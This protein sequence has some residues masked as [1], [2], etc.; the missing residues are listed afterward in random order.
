LSTAI[1]GQTIW[2]G[3]IFFDRT[4]AILAGGLMAIWPIQVAY[5]TI[6]ASELPFTFMV[7]LGFAAWFSSRPSKSAQAAVC[8]LAFGAASYVRPVALLLP[9]ILWL[10]I[11]PS[12]KKLGERLPMVVI[13]T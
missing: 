1:V 4:I 6:L 12:W 3:R 9:I 13:V 2:L 11:V 5:V 8:G 10:S 7:L